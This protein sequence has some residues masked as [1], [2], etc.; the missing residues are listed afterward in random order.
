MFYN[1]QERKTNLSFAQISFQ[2]FEFSPLS[3]GL[4]REWNRITSVLISVHSVTSVIRSEYFVHSGVVKPRRV[5]C[6]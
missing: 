2:I 4:S 6:S 3:F 5:V 1:K